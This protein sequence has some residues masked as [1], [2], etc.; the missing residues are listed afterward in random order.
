M[1]IALPIELTEEQNIELLRDFVQAVFV[2]EGMIADVN[3]HCDNKNNPHAHI[4]LSTREIIM[5]NG[6]YIFGNKVRYWASK[7]F[8]VSAR[9]LWAAYLNKHL[10]IHGFETEVSDLSYKALGID[11]VAGIKE[12]AGRNM[13]NSIRSRANAEI[14]EAN[15]KESKRIQN[16]L[17]MF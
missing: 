8:L 2:R 13:A 5:E 1:D 16:W 7:A 15:E 4:M 17:L 11:L 10:K 14:A 12:G 3:M 6:E 9:G